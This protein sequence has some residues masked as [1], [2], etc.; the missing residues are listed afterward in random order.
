MTIERMGGFADLTGRKFGTVR[1]ESFQGRNP[2]RWAVVCEVCSTRTIEQH[3]KLTQGDYRCKNVSCQL[4]RVQA[5]RKQIAPEPEIGKPA[6]VPVPF[7]TSNVS[8]EYKR[9]V[10]EMREWGHP[11]MKIGTWSEFQMLNDSQKARIMA[12]VI[13]AE[14]QREADALVAGLE[15]SERERMRRTYGV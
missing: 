2:V 10:R 3:H 9:Y 13:K 11:E 5:P 14:K 6:P 12:P 7:P 15:A 8:D 4:G 1:V